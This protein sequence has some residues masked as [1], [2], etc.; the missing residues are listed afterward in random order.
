MESINPETM[1]S[2]ISADDITDEQLE[3]LVRLISKKRNRN[4]PC[5]CRSGKK[6]KHCC[7]G[8]VKALQQQI[9]E[10]L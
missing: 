1:D 3:E 4:K 9:K 10:S 5:I 8:K 6:L 7:L 2:P